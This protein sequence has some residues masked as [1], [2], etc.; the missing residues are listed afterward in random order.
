MNTKSEKNKDIICLATRRIDDD[1]PTNVQHLMSRLAEKHRILYVEPPVDSVFLTR[2]PEFLVREQYLKSMCPTSLKPVWPSI[3]PYE[4][5]MP[6]FLPILNQY[7]II[8]SIRRSMQ[9]FQIKPE[10]LW[11]FRP[12]DYW[13]AKRIKPTVLCY[14]ITDKYNTMPVNA[15]SKN[16]IIKLD[17]LEAKIIK[18]ADIVFCTARS[19]W[20]EVSIQ[21]ERAF[22][23]GNVADVEHFSKATFPETPIP[24]DIIKLPKPVIGFFGSINSFKL[25][26]SLIQ[27]T[28][29]LYPN[30]SIAMIGPIKHAVSDRKNF[31]QNN[32][33][34]YLGTKDYKLLP[35]YLKGF[36]VC[37]IPYRKTSYTNHVFPLKIFEYLAAGKPVVSAALPSLKE[38]SDIIYLTNNNI[39]WAEA[40]KNALSENSQARFEERKNIAALNTWPVRI[41]EI[42]NYLTDTL[43]LN[44]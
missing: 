9:K 25:D 41:K 30:G 3:F 10:I 5:W 11:L 6:F 32:N 16:D 29:E 28:S 35:N 34:Y 33:I 39:E 15:R 8:Y 38:Y 43:V 23:T 24:D 22:F 42:E 21:H 44:L 18:R 37:I 7:K 17:K 12:Q 2:N 1:L 13:M 20:K 31:P 14:H 4:K 36:D 19:L 26:F 40:L 27:Q